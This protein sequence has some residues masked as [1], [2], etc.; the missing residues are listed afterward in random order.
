MIDPISAIAINPTSLNQP[1]TQDLAESSNL[2]ASWSSG[3]DVLTIRATDMVPNQPGN[4]L[5]SES[6]ANMS[7]HVHEGLR[8]SGPIN[9]QNPMQVDNEIVNEH[10]KT[11]APEFDSNGNKAAN[12]PVS[13]NTQDALNTMKKTFQH[14]IFSAMVTQVA[15]GVSNSVRMLARQS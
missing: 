12:G 6:F 4:P 5:T 10:I 8:F 2:S 14:A 1:T 15:S 3:P 9:S 11:L 13:Y 7:Q